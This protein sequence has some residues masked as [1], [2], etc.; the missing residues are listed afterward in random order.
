[1]DL[2]DRNVVIPAQE[3]QKVY[4]EIQAN[5]SCIIP[6]N[7]SSVITTSLKNPTFPTGSCVTAELLF[8]LEA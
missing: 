1:L 4:S 3:L 5:K 8:K 7:N 2:I 6:N